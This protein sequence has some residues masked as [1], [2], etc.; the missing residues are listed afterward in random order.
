VALVVVTGL[1]CLNAGYQHTL[2]TMLDLAV[3]RLAGTHLAHG[4]SIYSPTPGL[5]FTYPPFAAMLFVP[6]AAVG[7]GLGQGLMLVLSALCYVGFCWVCGRRSGLS[8]RV[9]WLVVLLGLGFE[10]VLH[11]FGLGQINLLLGLLVVVD[12]LLVSD[13]WRGLLVGVAVGIKLTPLVFVLYFVLR[14]D[15]RAVVRVLVGLGVSVALAWAVAPHDS[16]LYWG[17]LFYDPG[18]VG[19]VGYPFNQGIFGVLA[20]FTHSAHPPLLWYGALA[21]GT[22]ALTA[23]GARRQLAAGN[24]VA[25]LVT[26]ATC[27]LLLSPVSWTHHWIWLL[28]A[29][30][31]LAQAGHLVTALFVAAVPVME[32]LRYIPTPTD[33]TQ[34][35]LTWWQS[36]LSLSYTVAGLAVLAA[37]ALPC[38]TLTERDDGA[39][40]EAG[41]L[42]RRLTLTRRHV[43]QQLAGQPIGTGGEHPDPRP[44][45]RRLEASGG[46]LQ[47]QP[48]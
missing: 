14:R 15:G 25:G 33:L 7:I 16:R 10:P 38:E 11:T 46:P 40:R 4:V 36:G 3:Y 21:L 47:G 9:N 35:H 28:P 20:R 48:S 31:L 39:R 5:P 23:Y 41:P 13:K 26:V 17:R 45:S 32:P 6:L 34:L 2:W 12:C 8:T 44:A 42:R 27:G 19:R 18:H 37:M 29:S 24:Q 1:V 30:W 22:A 43:G